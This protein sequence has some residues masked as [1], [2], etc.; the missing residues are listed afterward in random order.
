MIKNF[1]HTLAV[2]MSGFALMPTLLVSSAIPVAADITD[3]E[4]L[5][6]HK[7]W[8]VSFVSF[9]DGTYVCMAQVGT[10]D[11]SFLIWAYSE[12]R[13]MLQFYDS[14]WQFNNE[15]ADIGLRIDRRPLWNLTNA[16]LNQNSV[17]FNLLDNNTSLR[18]MREVI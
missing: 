12:D 8:S 17:F 9:D 5:F 3:S 18:F 13:A 7:S 11:R 2:V 4:V 10:G 14:S 16:E 1:F 15:S 6:Q